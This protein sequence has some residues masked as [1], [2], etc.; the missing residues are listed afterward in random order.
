MTIL[1]TADIRRRRQ[2]LGLSKRRIAEHVGVSFT[3]ISRIEEG[4][5]H[6]D[7]SLQL[8][9]ALAGALGCQPAELFA[10]PPSTPPGPTAAQL[11]AALVNVDG[12]LPVDAIVE[13]LGWTLTD[14]DQTVRALNQVLSDAGLRCLEDDGLLR[15][16]PAHQALSPSALQQIVKA[17]IARR[18]LNPIEAQMLARA[19]DGTLTNQA[20]QGRAATLVAGRLRNAGYLTRDEPPGITAPVPGVEP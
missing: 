16:E 3:V 2:T 17:H 20:L 14:I 18:G 10:T 12:D 19:R 9:C 7:L 13:A 15:L 1:N 11:G 5:N 4:Q 6:P 8:L